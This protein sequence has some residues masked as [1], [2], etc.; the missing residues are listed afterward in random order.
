M[1]DPKVTRP[2][3]PGYGIAGPTDGT[4]L[5]PWSW[6]TERLT[7]SHDYWVATVRPDGTPALSPPVDP[8]RGSAGG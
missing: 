4:G 2:F 3:M 1:T 6:A 7:W 5:L 8:F